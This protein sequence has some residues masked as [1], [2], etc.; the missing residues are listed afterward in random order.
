MIR[1]IRKTILSGFLALSLC[2]TSVGVM[3]GTEVSVVKAAELTYTYDGIVYKYTLDEKNNATIWVK[4]N[5]AGKTT[6]FIE[7]SLSIPE[8]INGCPVTALG[9]GFVKYTMV[10]FV[11]PIQVTI[12]DS[13]IT[14]GNSA[15]SGCNLSQV[16][17]PD[18][19][20]TI[21]NSA[22]SGANCVIFKNP[23]TRVAEATGNSSTYKVTVGYE[24]SIASELVEENAFF[25]FDEYAKK[26]SGFTVPSDTTSYKVTLDHTEEASTPDKGVT[27]DHVYLTKTSLKKTSVEV[28]TKGYSDCTG[29][30]TSATGGT[31]MYDADGNP[32]KNLTVSNY[33]KFY[34]QWESRT[35][36]IRYHYNQKG[37]TDYVDNDTDNY[38]TLG[39]AAT[40]YTYGANL[41][42]PEPE[43]NGYNF[44]GWVYDTSNKENTKISSPLTSSVLEEMTD[45]GVDAANNKVIDLYATW[46]YADYTITYDFNDG[47]SANKTQKYTYPNPV[48][49]A[50]GFLVRDGYDF[51]EW[52]NTSTGETVE[53]S[54]G[55]QSYTYGNIT[56]QAQWNPRTYDITYIDYVNGKKVTT[57]A[58][59]TSDQ[60]L[61]FPKPTQESGD[62]R[63]FSW[64]QEDATGNT[65]EAESPIP[66]NSY[67]NLTYYATYDEQSY[68]IDFVTNGGSECNTITYKYADGASLPTPSKT[69]HDFLGWYKTA[70]FSG[71]KI[72]KIEEST[73]RG[74][75]T[76]YAKWKAQTYTYTIIEN[77][78]DLQYDKNG[79][80]IPR[81]VTVTYGQKMDLPDLKQNGM[82]LLGYSVYN[83]TTK[84]YD[85]ENLLKNGNYCERVGD[86]TIRAEWTNGI[87]TLYFNANGGNCSDASKT[88]VYKS[89]YDTLPTPTRKGYTFVGWY[90]G[91][92]DLVL[93]SSKVTAH[94][95]IT[96]YAHWTKNA[97]TPNVE[98]KKGTVKDG[99][100]TDINSYTFAKN[101][102]A[103]LKGWYKAKESGLYYQTL[104]ANA[105]RLYAFLWE[106]YKGGANIGKTLTFRLR[107]GSTNEISS[108]LT[109]FTYDHPELG[110]IGSASYTYM[111]A[112]G[113]YKIQFTPGFRYDPN[114]TKTAYALLSSK[115]SV[116]EKFFAKANIKKKDTTA[117]KLAKIEKLVLNTLAYAPATT[118]VNGSYG[119][120]T[121]DPVYV[122]YQ[123]KKHYSV[124][125][126]YAGL[127]QILCN[128]YGLTAN[129]VVG[130]HKSQSSW[131]GHGWNYAKIGKKWYLIDVTSDDT[132]YALKNG[133]RVNL[134]QAF[135]AGT[136]TK[137]NKK[138]VTAR[139]RVDTIGTKNITS[140]VKRSKKAYTWTKALGKLSYK[141]SSINLCKGKA[142]VSGLTK[143]GK[144]A[145]KVKLPN[146]I[147]LGGTSY[148]VTKQSKKALKK[149]YKK[150][151]K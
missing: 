21:G 1:K 85:T 63:A 123:S 133:K 80:I 55:F 24:P 8:S 38:G 131:N 26:V 5:E 147:K 36:K 12:P 76:L 48:S 77:G 35:Y 44:K 103:N 28:P 86:K 94:G 65:Y 129:Y 137:I 23:N 29:Y 56:L 30:Y 105:K 118:K 16:T 79:K 71:D 10:D 22:F 95:N 51:A 102:C 78:G 145:K 70:N 20:I 42:L 75:M 74:N 39:D 83:D 148:T 68:T 106:N 111:V 146:K 43:R 100:Y 4:S 112:D 25:T 92:G 88:I 125:A 57:N 144:K 7:D 141:I 67:K 114:K 6:Y 109:A 130:D 34:A 134:F 98:G 104:N 91:E 140:L 58:T 142:K 41:T 61:K 9:D 40:T 116:Y 73:T 90:T 97:E 108:A 64:W 31:Q 139:Y 11:D 50:Y 126:A 47:K 121:R 66:T 99:T 15:F 128:Y 33:G 53:S 46:E 27:A 19:V 82:F 135:L 87:Y 107:L 18:S 17:I 32:T 54:V 3:P 49:L 84:A 96:L 127:T 69:G 113:N 60:E 150:K 151:V 93:S 101:T 89:A 138:K 2:A 13:V 62:D 110:W 115:A 120:E 149:K 119:N 37:D 132:G 59:Y 52:K 122:L 136:K 124:C 14:I 45:N 143:K 81:T 72:T 117:Q